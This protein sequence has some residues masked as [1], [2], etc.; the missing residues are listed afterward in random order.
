MLSENGSV[1]TE[2][3]RELVTRCFGPR[4]GELRFAPLGEDSWSYTWQDLWI[5]VRR[6]VQGHVPAAYEGAFELHRGGLDFVLAPLAG[7]DGSVVRYLA[8][9]PVVVFPLL[10]AGQ[11]GPGAPLTAS[12]RAEVEEMLAALHGFAAPD[13]LPRE[14]FTLPFADALAASPAAGPGAGPF[15]E[16]FAA[17]VRS[18]ADRLD[19]L[20]AERDSLMHE[21]RA[22]DLEFVVTHGDLNGGNVL[23]TADRLKL[24]DWGM[25]QWAPPERD[26]YHLSRTLGFPLRGDA[27]V[28]RYYELR[29]QL[30][31]IAEYAAVFTRPHGDSADTRAMWRRLL[32]YLP[33]N[34]RSGRPAVR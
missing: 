23:R 33:E 34:E 9:F 21:L 18:N 28:L 2:L 1:D 13:R 14:E 26:R 19:A 31:E 27:N 12:E 11:I 5:S 20:Q 17:L 25:L 22:R 6:D 15:G 29:W 8:G 10:E 7:A 30:S 24:A 3:L 32:A 4:D 16:R